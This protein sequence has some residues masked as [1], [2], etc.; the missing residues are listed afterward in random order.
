[1]ARSTLAYFI[2]FTSFT[3]SA[4]DN[5]IT[6]GSGGGITGAVT[7]YKITPKGKV[8]RGN[9][10]GEIRYVEC[11]KVKRSF[12]KE[13]I[14]SVH[15]EAKKNAPFNHPG[16]VYYFIVYHDKGVEYKVTWGDTE[17]PVP[18]N[19]RKLYEIMQKEVSTLP[20]KPIK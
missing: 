6:L 9:G 2:F 17:H 1:M 4:Q 14:A 8:F 18:D 5:F 3:A 16:N 15:S 12:A 19:V 20:Y 10:V 13:N 11:S 7:S